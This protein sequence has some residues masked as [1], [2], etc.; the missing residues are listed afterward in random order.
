M[1]VNHEQALNGALAPWEEHLLQRLCT[2]QREPLSQ[3]VGPLCEALLNPLH[4]RVPRVLHSIL[5]NF[6][7]VRACFVTFGG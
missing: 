5:E 6:Q 3:A 1:A 7:T 2:W 4:L